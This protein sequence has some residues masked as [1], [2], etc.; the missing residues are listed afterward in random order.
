M[1]DLWLLPS[2]PQMHA[3]F[4]FTKRPLDFSTL[5]QTQA[6]II[7]TRYSNVIKQR[8]HVYIELHHRLL[9]IQKKNDASPFDRHVDIVTKDYFSQTN[10]ISWELLSLQHFS[11]KHADTV[12][13]MMH[14]TRTDVSFRLNS[15][16]TYCHVP[17]AGICVSAHKRTVSSRS[18]C[19][20]ASLTRFTFKIWA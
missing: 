6:A 9:D 15:Q 17:H 11:S 8:R 20:P 14:V 3:I 10:R 16:N 12:R 13:E 5:I 2:R 1:E 4:G 18:C 19:T 7:E